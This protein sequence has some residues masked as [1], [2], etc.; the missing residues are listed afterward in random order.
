MRNNESVFNWY[1]ISR[2]ES[3]LDKENDIA[4]EGWR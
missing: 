3:K 2:A 4:E 1:P